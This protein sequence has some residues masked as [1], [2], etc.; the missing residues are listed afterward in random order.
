MWITDISVT[1]HS[2][3]VTFITIC[4]L[5]GIWFDI[6]FEVPKNFHKCPC[7]TGITLADPLE[8]LHIYNIF[9][10]ES[11]PNIVLLLFKQNVLLAIFTFMI[12]PTRLFVVCTILL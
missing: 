6:F 4:R 11:L 2:K 9:F 12:D 7:K 10:I 5:Q 3:V 1:W 8:S